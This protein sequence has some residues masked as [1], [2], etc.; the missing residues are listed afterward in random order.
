MFIHGTLFC[1]IVELIA[2][3]HLK[4]EN[5]VH[6]PCCYLFQG[7]H[8][9]NHG[10]ILQNHW[11]RVVVSLMFHTALQCMK[12]QRC[13]EFTTVNSLIHP[14]AYIPIGVTTENIC[15]HSDSAEFSHQPPNL[16]RLSGLGPMM[17]LLPRGW[18]AATKIPTHGLWDMVT[19]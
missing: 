12:P 14:S 17:T 2:E 10:L 16:P 9:I 7:S 8:I 19:I 6:C 13:W 18:G 1:S 5:T 3:R 15:L 4:A 11:I